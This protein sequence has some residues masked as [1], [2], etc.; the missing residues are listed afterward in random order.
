MVE[1]LSVLSADEQRLTAVWDG[2]TVDHSGARYSYSV[3]DATEKFALL[4]F[5]GLAPVIVGSQNEDQEFV[6]WLVSLANLLR[7]MPEQVTWL[8]ALRDVPSR[9]EIGGEQVGR[10]QSG[11]RGATELLLRDGT[12]GGSA[13]SKVSDWYERATGNSLRIERAAFK[14]KD[15]FSVVLNPVRSAAASAI[16][17]TGEGM[18]QVY[19]VV[20]FLASQENSDTK[21]IFAV[22]HPELHLHPAAHGELASL[23]CS[24]AQRGHVTS[25]VETHSENFLLRVQLEIAEG[26][27]RPDAVALYWVRQ[28]DD[29]ARV[30]AIEFDALGRPKDERW[31]P[32]MFSENIEQAR[33][34]AMVR[35]K[36]LSEDE[37]RS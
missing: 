20:A 8:K 11:G 22:E 29:G 13:L 36:K 3:G 12:N 16:A 7:L 10:L 6:G 5:D 17:D 28:A 34:L 14:N 21:A 15:L 37:H 9:I 23:F 4:A 30:E 2:E 27:L 1:R 18:A 33:Q 19:P 32:G 25:V 26:R 31:P 35:R 24:V